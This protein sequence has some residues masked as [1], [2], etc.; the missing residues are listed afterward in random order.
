[1]NSELTVDYDQF[2]DD[3]Y[4]S[5]S[6]EILVFSWSENIKEHLFWSLFAMLAYRYL[7]FIPIEGMS[8]FISKIL[9]Y[10]LA[11]V[12]GI[13]FTWIR[14]K[15]GLG[16]CDGIND[17]IIP[18]AIYSL[19]AFSKI[20]KWLWIIQ[21]LALIVIVTFIIT[22][23]KKNS[24]FYIYESE[25]EIL[26]TK[27]FIRRVIVKGVASVLFLCSIVSVIILSPIM[28]CF[29]AN[30]G[31]FSSSLK[32]N[33]ARD[34]RSYLLENFDD[35]SMTRS[36]EEWKNVSLTERV[37]ITQKIVNYILADRLGVPFDVSVAVAGECYNDMHLLGSYADNNKEIVISYYVISSD[38]PEELLNVVFHE[39]FHAY[40]YALCEAYENVPDEYRN[41]VVFENCDEYVYEFTHYQSGRFGKDFNAYESQRIE[42]DADNFASRMILE[43]YSMIDNSSC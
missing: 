27:R 42:N 43:W 24:S 19:L 11:S 32:H 31:V 4:T 7:M 37:D 36:S 38:N 21:V 39:C 23:V 1:M 8:V 16:P 20:Y 18:V 3:D 35:F 34:C 5:S 30:V 6:D 22:Y 10:S 29:V 9:F 26:A 2:I 12:L 40:E 15:T 28:L 33:N 14:S 25:D 17:S 41:L 13:V